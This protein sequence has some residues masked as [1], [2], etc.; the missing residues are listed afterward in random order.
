MYFVWHF[1]FRRS[2]T[3]MQYGWSCSLDLFF[4]VP[5]STINLLKNFYHL[6][7][8]HILLD[9]SVGYVQKLTTR[10]DIDVMEDLDNEKSL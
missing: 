4:L 10:E 6:R 3:K 7:K 2:K 5:I 1:S 8:S 9:C